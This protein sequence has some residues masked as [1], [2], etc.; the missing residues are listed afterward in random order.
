L[1]GDTQEVEGEKGRREEVK[2]S[3]A[4]ELKTKQRK[5]K[6]PRAKQP[7]PL[8]AK[9]RT[10]R[11]QTRKP[12]PRRRR[13][14]SSG[15]ITPRIAADLSTSPW[16][17][18]PEQI[19]ILT[20]TSLKQLM[21][22]LVLAQAY[23]CAADISKVIVNTEDKAADDGC[24]AWTPAPPTSDEWLSAFNTCWQFK[25][26]S[27]GTPGGL[28]SEVQKP[29]PV[30]TLKAGGRFVAV[31]S[32]AGGGVKERKNRIDK[33]KLGAKK[34]R[35]KN[36]RLEVLTSETLANWVNEH[37][38]IAA[39]VRGMPRGCWTLAKWSTDTLHKEPWHSTAKLSAGI[40]ILQ[41]TL[42][43]GSGQAL[44]IHVYGQ[45][46][47]GKTRL[48]LEA[49]RDAKWSAH[50]MYVP[51]ASDARIAEL[52]DTVA[53]AP[54]ARLVLVVDEVQSQQV[55]GFNASVRTSGGRVRLV[56]IGHDG[57]PDS[58][59]ID[60]LKVDVLDDETMAKV[61]KSWYPSFPRE[62]VDFVVRYADGFVRLARLV[63]HAVAENPAINVSGLMARNDIRQLMDAMLGKADRR[64]L[65]VVAILTS[66]GWTGERAVEGEAV[67]KHFGLSWADVQRQVEEVHSKHGIAPRG[68][69]LRY[70]SPRPLGVYLALDALVSV[71]EKVRTLPEALPN[72]AARSAHFERLKAM[73]ADAAAELFVA[74]ELARFSTWDHFVEP[75]AVERWAAWAD[76]DPSTAARSVKNALESATHDQRLLIA[77]ASR[78][79]LVHA[80]VDLAWHTNAFEDAVL[81]LAELAEAEN[82]SWANNA[83]A[84]LMSKY[85][86]VLGG[87]ACPYLDRLTAIDELLSRP[88][89]YQRL[90]IAALGKIGETRGWRTGAGPS[91]ARIRPQEWHPTTTQRIQ[92][93]HAALERLTRVTPTVP[94]ELA[95]DLVAV[96]GE[97]VE[98][99][100]DASV[101]DAVATFIRSVVH[102][103][104]SLRESVRLA[105]YRTLDW[106][107]KY[108][109]ELPA[110]NLAWLESFHGELEDRS[111]SGQLRQVLSRS[112]WEREEDGDGDDDLD[113]LA[114]YVI[115]NPQLLASEWELLTSGTLAAVWDFGE[116]LA[117][118]D[119][120]GSL[121]EQ[122]VGILPRGS[123]LR[124]LA[125]YVNERAKRE[126]PGWI[127]DLVD[128]TER[129]APADTAL[130]VDLTWRCAPTSR[131]AQRL[132]RYAEAGRLGPAMVSQLVFGGWSLGPE[133]APLAHLLRVLSANGEQ[134]S[135]VLALV[136]QRLSKHPQDL[137]VLDE[138]ALRLVTTPELVRAGGMTEHTWAQVATMLLPVH[139][140]AIA[141]TIFQ[142]QE[143]RGERSWFIEHSDASQVL[144]GC[145][146]ADP[147]GV[148]SHLVPYLEGP[149]RGLFSIG[150]PVGVLS[151]LPRPKV[152]AWIGK[153]PAHRAAL[154][155]RMVEK[156]FT[157]GT[158]GAELLHH[159]RKLDGIGDSFFSAFVSGAWSGHA[160]TRW[161][162][163]AE[164]LDE[165]AR[166]SRL[167]GVT[168][169]AKE[170]AARLRVM[171]KH[172][173]K[174]EEEERLR[175]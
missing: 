163:L 81:A 26:G 161:E 37:P 24:D 116:A 110:E 98:L 105:V 112:R 108:G 42:D 50:V 119:K 8:M 155:A 113:L 3:R 89:S 147:E 140:L 118:A 156:V 2:K 158:L 109:K 174:R 46:G 56:T 38:A 115:Q 1:N 52:L 173:R 10:L 117:R 146:V 31:T 18:S 143:A 124:L 4:R 74:D 171:A 17:V 121:F 101:R 61:V 142:A 48:V 72:D 107:R 152:L 53:D 165:T 57:S 34:A 149:Q 9:S 12:R 44:H 6:A 60:E 136:Q 25:A 132:S 41:R 102:A 137:P 96:V 65:Q 166:T 75:L 162:A 73:V 20:D 131:G 172:D 85:H 27:A 160:S 94:G 21:R 127:D 129:I 47:A 62:H 5:A 77:D 84:E 59:N 92:A 95:A 167:A 80:L 69:D 35:L 49:C 83:T 103:M 88:G 54:A 29:K 154:V 36:P 122:M 45:P 51:Q 157:D 175:W 71:P 139:A 144:F 79:H 106:E 40:A 11:K 19:R 104:P 148:W 93:A 151:E 111:P 55:A 67:A 91:D 39:A 82:E 123:D 164:D 120:S 14:P 130:L 15:S 126:R 33:L 22:N 138:I 168:A 128:E 153:D 63:S 43:L 99:L 23:R 87:T 32:K 66:V 28:V 125:G 133:V 90:G 97:L 170:S 64:A 70:V 100:R 159:Y 7:T 78:R 114:T 169:W 13:K 76:G 135:G 58:T 150:F 141:E 86:L 30:E 68:G 145:V 16:V 134:R